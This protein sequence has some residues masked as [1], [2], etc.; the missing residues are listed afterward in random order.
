MPYNLPLLRIP[1]KLVASLY[2]LTCRAQHRR[3]QN[4]ASQITGNLGPPLRQV[5][6]YTSNWH[7]HI[8]VDHHR[9]Q[10]L[11]QSSSEKLLTLVKYHTLRIPGGFDD[12]LSPSH[13]GE[14]DL[15]IVMCVQTLYYQCE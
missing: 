10:P 14:A 11:L 12:L 1:I 8:N 15:M 2:H 4:S 9:S 6:V 13:G 3:A 5:S 7:T